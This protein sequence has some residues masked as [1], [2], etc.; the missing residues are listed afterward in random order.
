MKLHF[1]LD[2]GSNHGNGEHIGKVL[3]QVYRVYALYA[4]SGK[5][6]KR[7]KTLEVAALIPGT[8]SDVSLAL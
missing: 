3:G 7:A 8:K 5:L 1:R 2:V 4:A 6:G